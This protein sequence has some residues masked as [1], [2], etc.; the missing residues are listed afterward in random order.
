MQ[1]WEYRLHAARPCDSML[2]DGADWILFVA[3]VVVLAAGVLAG[4]A[5]L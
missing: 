3:V 2:S 4:L 1:G 5:M